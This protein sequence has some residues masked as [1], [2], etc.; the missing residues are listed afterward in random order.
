MGAKMAGVDVVLAIDKD[1]AAT[2]CYAFNLGKTTV[3]TAK[4]ESIDWNVL[5]P[6][7]GKFDLLLAGFPCQ[8][9]SP[10]NRKRRSDPR[11]SEWRK[12]IE[13]VK[14]LEP[15][16]IVLENVAAF[17]G[18]QECK[19]LERSLKKLGYHVAIV[20]LD[21]WDYGVAQ[22]RLR[23]FV[24]A[25]AV[26]PV[27]IPD[28]IPGKEERTVRWALEGLPKVPNGENDHE[29]RKYSVKTME[30]F[31]HLVVP[32][33]DWRDLPWDLLSPTWKRLKLRIERGEAKG[34]ASGSFGRLW[35]DKPA[36]TIRTTFT[37]VETGR[38]VHPDQNRGITPREAARLQGFP[39]WFKFVGSFD[40]K[41]ILIG[42]AVP[43]PLAKEVVRKVMETLF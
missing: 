16:G 34:T 4:I 20:V 17:R 7:F 36:P 8:P 42:N 31:K 13:V 19:D 43:P 12:I 5:I 39:D 6:R 23:T 10:S 29:I 33:G 24:L 22:R 9:F 27:G 37:K 15:L 18:S 25:S 38:F 21:A 14:K 30:R 3:L 2:A 11:R 26:N 1:K 28:P 40:Q 41:G 35:W 32:G